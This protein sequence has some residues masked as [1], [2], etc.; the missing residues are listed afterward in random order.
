MVFQPYLEKLYPP[1]GELPRSEETAQ[2]YN[3]VAAA[4]KADKK[5]ERDIPSNDTFARFVGRAPRCR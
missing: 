5:A 1:N 2:A 3:K 4:M